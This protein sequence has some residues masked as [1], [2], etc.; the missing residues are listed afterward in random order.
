MD[1]F[2]GYPHFQTV[3]WD[4]I[5]CI[6]VTSYLT[7]WLQ[8]GISEGEAENCRSRCEK[9]GLPFYRFN[10]ELSEVIAL[11]ESD[12]EKLIDMVLKTQLYLQS[13][14][15]EMDELVQL[16]K[17]NAKFANDGRPKFWAPL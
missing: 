4:D 5:G 17:H 12:N 1:K 8:I 10:P 15:Y 9:Q 14:D 2:R 11:S 13:K 3:L 16:C 6:P 7:S